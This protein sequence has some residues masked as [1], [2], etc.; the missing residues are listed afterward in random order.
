MRFYSK[1]YTFDAFSSVIHPKTS[2]NADAFFGTVCKSFYSTCPYTK[3][4]VFETMRL[5]KTPLLIP[6]SK[7]FGYFGVGH[8]RKSIIKKY[9]FSNGKCIGVVGA[10]TTHCDDYQYH[11][12]YH[13][14]HRC[15]YCHHH[16]HCHHLK[17]PSPKFNLTRLNF[18]S[19]VSQTPP[20]N[21]SS[22]SIRSKYSHKQAFWLSSCLHQ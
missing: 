20:G 12:Y 14:H 6:F 9:V 2:E 8:K 19:T 11:L 21:P 5:Q 18:P 1:T 17:L 7:V 3:L 15:R 13:N 10:S 4:K 22:Q 16:Y